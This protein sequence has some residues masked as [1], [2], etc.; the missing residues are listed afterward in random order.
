MSSIT[1]M[2]KNNIKLKKKNKYLFLDG[3]KYEINSLFTKIIFLF[4]LQQYTHK[5]YIIIIYIYAI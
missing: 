1:I 2:F 5:N 4:Y 3:L